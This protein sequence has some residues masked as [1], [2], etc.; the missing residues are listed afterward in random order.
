MCFGCLCINFAIVILQK[1][2]DGA[3]KILYGLYAVVEHM[4]STL[5][6]GHYIAYVK[7]R[8]KRDKPTSP[9]ATDVKWLYDEAAA[10]EG[11]WFRT[12]DLTIKECKDFKE[13]EGS[14]PYLLFYELLPSKTAK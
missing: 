3:N 12:S 6:A 8:P 1:F 14:E 2:G 5:S 10:S 4:G 9:K 11:I 7:R 13:V